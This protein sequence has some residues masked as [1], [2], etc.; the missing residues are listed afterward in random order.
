MYPTLYDFQEK[1]Y[2]YNHNADEANIYI[3]VTH[4]E[5]MTKY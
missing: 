3:A 5:N 4:E 2:V 1:Q